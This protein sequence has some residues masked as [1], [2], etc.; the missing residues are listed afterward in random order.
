[1]EFES[2][3]LIHKLFRVLSKENNDFWLE[4]PDVQKAEIKM[5]LKQNFYPTLMDLIKK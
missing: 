4:L 3:D 1:L 2:S 5:G